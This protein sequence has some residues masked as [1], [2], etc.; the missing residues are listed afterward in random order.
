MVLTDEVAARV[1]GE[2]HTLTRKIDE[3][4]TQVM[5]SA[6]F[7]NSAANLIKENSVLAVEKAREA[8]RLAQ[9]ESLAHF[10]SNMSKAVAT[11]LTDVANAV[12]TKSAVQ[13]IV[14]GVLLAG[15]FAVV[16]GVLGYNSG[17][18]AGNDFGYAQAR[19]EIAAAAWANTPN[20]KLA[21]RLEKS[22]ELEHILR[23]NRPNPPKLR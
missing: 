4:S 16:A 19:D 2:L 22:G 14:G 1:M 9:L 13:W 3:Q 12:A 23:C 21:F 5:Q 18:D 10:E 8:T 20:G 17:K 6:S 15:T 7:I 11:T